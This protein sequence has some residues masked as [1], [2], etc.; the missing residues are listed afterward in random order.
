MDRC[1][2]RSPPSPEECTA[3]RG[4]AR[5]LR[6]EAGAGAAAPKPGNPA[7]PL[8]SFKHADHGPR[9][10]T[11]LWSRLRTGG[12]PRFTGRCLVRALF[13]GPKDQASLKS[14]QKAAGFMAVES[15]VPYEP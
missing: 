13:P 14:G 9:P 10:S 12:R 2:R 5:A 1:A 4:S 6:P 11:G 8:V 3:R 15:G 7:E